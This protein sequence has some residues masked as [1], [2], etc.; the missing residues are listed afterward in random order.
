MGEAIRKHAVK[1]DGKVFMIKGLQCGQ[2]CGV[3][4]ECAFPDCAELGEEFETEEDAK[5]KYNDIEIH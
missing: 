5:K 1:I 4:F 2:N 3:Q